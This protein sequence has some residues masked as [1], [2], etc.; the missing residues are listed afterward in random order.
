[1]GDVN[2][3]GEDA[4]GRRGDG[5]GGP[6]GSQIALEV[7]EEAVLVLDRWP[8]DV[9]SR[10]GGRSRRQGDVAAVDVDNRVRSSDRRADSDQPR[11]E[12][13]PGEQS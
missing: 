7:A 4:E 13:Q 1:M 5:A 10:N 8:R 2:V 12:R 6:G 3:P 9:E 11:D